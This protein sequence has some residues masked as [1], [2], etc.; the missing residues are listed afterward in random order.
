VK[1]VDLWQRLQAACAR[2]WVEWFWVK[3]HAGIP[4]N[5]LADALAAQGMQKAIARTVPG[6]A[7]PR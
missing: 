5:E 7:G 3:G 6:G 2:H 4:D 1:N